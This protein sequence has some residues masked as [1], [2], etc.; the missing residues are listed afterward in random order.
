MTTSRTTAL[1]AALHDQINVPGGETHTPK[2]PDALSSLVKPLASLSASL[3]Y[4]AEA[5][6]DRLN[7]NQAAFFLIAAAADARGVPLT[8]S[9]IM[10]AT[11]GVLNRSL[12]NTYKVLLA[13]NNRDYKKIG[14]GWLMREPDPEDE[15]RH[16]L[17]LTRTGQSV[18]R[19]ALL[20]LGTLPT[21]KET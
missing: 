21:P 4:L 13:P 3:M 15:R 18:A 9:E 8:L 7:I 14:L 2:T 12:S 6:N 11:E 1:D 19:A 10:A 16:Y 20:A 5:G 17:R